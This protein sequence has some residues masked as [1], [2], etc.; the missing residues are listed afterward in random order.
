MRVY[1]RAFIQSTLDHQTDMQN[2]PLWRRNIVANYFARIAR[3]QCFPAPALSKRFRRRLHC[4]TSSHAY[5]RQSSDSRGRTIRSRSLLISRRYDS[6][7]SAPL[8]RASNAATARGHTPRRQTTTNFSRN[9]LSYHSASRWSVLRRVAKCVSRG[10]SLQRSL[11]WPLS[12][13]LCP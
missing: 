3:P 11:A 7:L 2:H 5:A 12:H 13:G 1:S 4:W 10:E 8:R 6:K 9:L